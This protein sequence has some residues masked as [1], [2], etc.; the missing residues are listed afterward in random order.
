[1]LKIINL[2][3]VYKTGT[4]ALSTISFSVK[5]GEFIS[6]IGPSGCGKST[7]LR[8]INRLVIPSEG[9]ILF[10]KNDICKMGNAEL[11]DIRRTM[12]MVFQQF[13]LIQ[14]HSVLKNVLYGGLGNMGVIKSLFNLFN[15][16]D[17]TL[18]FHNL[19]LM[20]L[21]GKEHIRVNQLSGGQQQ[22]VAIARTLMQSPVLILADE[23][24][25]SLDPIS[26]D[27]VMTHLQKLNKER[28]MTVVTAVHSV[29]L[30]KKYSSRVIG[31]H[32]GK[33]IFDGLPDEL[34]DSIIKKIYEKDSDES[35]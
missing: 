21:S 11:R 26:S 25:A 5:K 30:V 29:S 3:K 13:N 19:S 7:L 6:I 18:A 9:Q 10:Y 28:N 16:H 22:R 17:I 2:S 14:R 12:G 35:T 8:C 4:V 33:I 20:G 1:M 34:D 31:L 24:V 32:S 27:V 15:P 23:P